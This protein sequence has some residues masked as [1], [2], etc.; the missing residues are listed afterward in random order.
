MMNS[1]LIQSSERIRDHLIKQKQQSS[2]ESGEC[3]YRGPNGLMCA[4]GALIHDE[5]YNQEFEH[6]SFFATEEIQKAVFD[7]LMKEGVVIQEDQEQTVV[8]LL[9]Q[10]QEYHDGRYNLWIRY[11]GEYNSPQC[12]HEKMMEEFQ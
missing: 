8:A 10:W 5:F 11:G 4:V 1:Q 6:N 2:D 12:F 9:Q 3:F 7:S